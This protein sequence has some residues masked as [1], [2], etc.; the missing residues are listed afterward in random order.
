MKYVVAYEYDFKRI[1]TDTNGFCALDEENDAI[2]YLDAPDRITAAINFLSVE[3]DAM[4]KRRDK[5]EIENEYEKTM[6]AFIESCVW[7]D[8]LIEVDKCKRENEICKLIGDINK[9]YLEKM[10]EDG[11][12]KIMLINSEPAVLSEDSDN[13]E[14]LE[15]VHKKFPADC[16]LKLLSKEEKKKLFVEANLANVVVILIEKL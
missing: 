8:D 3:Y 13:K 4:L 10:M 2:K 9:F 15:E 6:Q 5:M 11:K 16:L 12:V 7:G 1:Q 14:E